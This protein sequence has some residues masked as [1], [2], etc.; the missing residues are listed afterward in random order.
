L[1]EAR[2]KKICNYVREGV[3][4]EV[5]ARLAGVHPATFHR[6][7]TRGMQAK[8]GIYRKFWEALQEADAQAEVKLLREVR[9]EKGGP[10]W[11]MERRWPE[12]WGQKIEMRNEGMAFVMDWGFALEDE[13]DGDG[14][15]AG[16]SGEDAPKAQA[17]D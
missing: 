4:Y 12:R 11:I 17:T 1:D 14:A 8:R 15:E 13:D 5:A 10:K 7:K 6:W 2:I 9:K 16:D 3:T